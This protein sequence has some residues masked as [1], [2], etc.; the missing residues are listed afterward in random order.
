M[1]ESISDAD[2][3][4]FLQLGMDKERMVRRLETMQ[5]GAIAAVIGHLCSTGS[6]GATMDAVRDAG[7]AMIDAKLLEKLDRLDKTT[8]RL[9]IVGIVLGVIVGV[10][11]I[12]VPLLVHR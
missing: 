5:P 10:A 7:R 6:L 9:T 12:M 1:A 2:I 4:A 11:G 8:A 3:Q